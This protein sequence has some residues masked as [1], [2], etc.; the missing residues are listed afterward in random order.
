MRPMDTSYELANG[1]RH[2]RS[3]MHSNQAD[4]DCSTHQLEKFRS[5]YGGSPR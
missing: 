1:A 4:L 3:A 5:Q 2:E